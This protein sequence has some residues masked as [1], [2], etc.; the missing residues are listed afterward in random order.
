MF[1]LTIAFSSCFIYLNYGANRLLNAQQPWFSS[2]SELSLP[3]PCP[4]DE[5]ARAAPPLLLVDLD[6]GT[7]L[8]E[9]ALLRRRSSP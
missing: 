8:G 9:T 5:P 7:R 6:A 4:S 1:H 2:P 3:S